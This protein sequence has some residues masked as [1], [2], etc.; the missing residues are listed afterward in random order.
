MKVEWLYHTGFN[1]SD[2]DQS[3]EFYRDLL[4]LEVT[5]DLVF[6]GE[7][8]DKLGGLPESKAHIVFAGNGDDRHFLELVEWLSPVRK[9]A[10]NHS[11]GEWILQR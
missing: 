10:H 5:R 4:G 1:V 3:L 9:A 7:I 2:M 6:E 11:C 8:L